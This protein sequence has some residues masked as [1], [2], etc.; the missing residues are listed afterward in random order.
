MLT[1]PLVNPFNSTDRPVE[2]VKSVFVRGGDDVAVFK[3]FVSSSS[4]DDHGSAILIDDLNNFL[5]RLDQIRRHE[6]SS[7]NLFQTRPVC[8]AESAGMS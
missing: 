6:R 5:G 4:D 7:I 2:L 1:G 8:V 3:F